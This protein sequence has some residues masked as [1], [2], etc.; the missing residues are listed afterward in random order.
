MA[1]VSIKGDS[2][3]EIMKCV[4]RQYRAAGELL[5]LAHRQTLKHLAKTRQRFPSA[6]EMKM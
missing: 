5:L 6:K 3:G 2:D 4:D 1:N